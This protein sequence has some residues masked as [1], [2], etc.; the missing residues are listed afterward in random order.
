MIFGER[1]EAARWYVVLVDNDKTV[2][3]N[4]YA[5]RT[6]SEANQFRKYHADSRLVVQVK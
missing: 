1:K 3:P 2:L 5:F 4:A 6:E